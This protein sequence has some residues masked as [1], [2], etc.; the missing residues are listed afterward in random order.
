M[1]RKFLRVTLGTD[2]WYATVKCPLAPSGPEIEKALTELMKQLASY[3]GVVP[4]LKV[5]V[6]EDG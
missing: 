1:K 3:E 4:R 2:K 6:E 5:K